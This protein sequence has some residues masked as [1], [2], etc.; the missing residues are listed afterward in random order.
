MG[1]LKFAARRR[2]NIDPVNMDFTEADKST[3]TI[4][5][6]DSAF[7]KLSLF[8]RSSN[9]SEMSIN[10]TLSFFRSL[11]ESG[12]AASTVTTIKS[13]LAKPFFYGFDLNLNDYCFSSISRSCARLRPACVRRCVLGLLTRFFVWHRRSLMILPLINFFFGRLSSFLPWLP[14]LVSLNWRP[15]PEIKVS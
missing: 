5:Q 8:I 12:L 10:S 2:F 13:A 1:F 11:H 14:G 9:L 6:Y 7:K 3:S 4:R 15:Y